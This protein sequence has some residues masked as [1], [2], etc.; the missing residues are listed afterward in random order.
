M[1]DDGPIDR[2]ELAG[3]SVHRLRIMSVEAQ[4]R[5]GIHGAQIVHTRFACP[6]AADGSGVLDQEAF[7]GGFQAPRQAV[8]SAHLRAVG[9]L[10]GVMR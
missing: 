6:D 9:R 1:L 3:G 4:V 5:K 7:F 8:N 2:V 10:G